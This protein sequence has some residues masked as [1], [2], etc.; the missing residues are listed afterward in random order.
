MH[1][2][3]F[4][5]K[6]SRTATSGLETR[7]EMVCWDCRVSLGL[8]ELAFDPF[9]FE[10]CRDNTNIIDLIVTSSMICVQKAKI[11]QTLPR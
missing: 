10:T 7:G 5:S 8:L 2:T 6:A 11:A 9:I 3:C 1:S 4:L